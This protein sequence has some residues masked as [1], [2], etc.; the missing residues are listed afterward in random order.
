MIFD[1][2]NEITQIV[3]HDNYGEFPHLNFIFK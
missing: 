3:A 1:M 2:N